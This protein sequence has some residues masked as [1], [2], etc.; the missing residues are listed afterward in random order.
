MKKIA[1]IAALCSFLMPL[2]AQSSLAG[3]DNFLAAKRLPAAL[4]FGNAQGFAWMGVYD[5][6]GFFKDDY[7]LFFA[8]KNLGYVLDRMGSNNKHR[9]IAAFG[10][11]KE[12]GNLYFGSAWDWQNKKFKDGYYSQSVLFRPSD[13]LSLAASFN[14]LFHDARYYEV[15]AAIRP[16]SKLAG[17]GNRITFGIESTYQND[18]WQKPVLSI[19]TELLDGLRLGGNYDLYNEQIGLHFSLS[20][21]NLTMGTYARSDTDNKF[22]YG[23][24]FVHFSDRK[25]KSLFGIEKETFVQFKLKGELLDH[26]KV[27]PLGPLNLVM[28]TGKTID[29]AIKELKQLKND[30]NIAGIIFINEHFASS[31]ALRQ[32]LIEAINEFK[33]AGKKV[34]FYYES[35]GG[36]NYAFAAAVADQIYLNPV[37]MIEFKGL[38]A[39]LPY[40]NSLLDTLGIDIV[41]MRSHDY[42][43]AVN[44]FSESHMTDAERETYEAL[45][46]GIFAEISAMIENGR[47][48]RLA[49]PLSELINEKPF[50]LPQE[51]IEMGLIDGLAFEDELKDLLDSLYDADK[52][53]RKYSAEQYRYDWSDGFPSRI[54]VIHAIGN[55]HSG[56]G[57]TGK[58]IGS[59][60]LASTIKQAREDKTIKGIILRVDSGGGSAIASDVIAREIQLCKTGKNKKPVVVSMSG[61]AA[62]GGYYI[63]MFAD[64]IVC[65]PSTITGSIGVV[66]MLPVMER[67]YQKI[68]INW[69]TVKI[70]QYADF[71]STNRKPTETEIG[72]GEEMIH[73]FYDRFITL[74]AEGRSMNKEDV[75]SVAQ[76]RVWTGKQA[77]ERGLVDTLGGMKTASIEMQ[78]LLNTDKE[79][80]LIVYKKSKAHKSISVPV[81]VQS[82]L[83]REI[84]TFLELADQI[85]NTENDKIMMKVPFIPE[86]K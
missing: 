28:N 65:Q 44:M 57:V 46:D 77:L 71:Q 50:W 61:T 29:E 62:S 27:T 76:G 73:H 74:V 23:Q 86:F 31:I 15:G 30:E 14:D 79:L 84:Q 7:S 32:E 80:D 78:K 9:L 3:T 10:D 21:Q 51:A 1:L 19:D 52:I 12:S 70:G 49:K 16:L 43:T 81:N 35:V 60:S 54:A 53:S 17:L 41:N 8:A 68:H 37:G 85:K 63:S 40:F 20:W 56:K 36:A 58:S 18:E 22:D 26:K 34:V 25:L 55:I 82:R 69:D 13:F 67:L 45:L 24:S 4:A 47:G 6:D 75:H 64:K 5:E 11:G 72:F 59:E 83:P 39:S 2:V 66:G 33:A 38:L 42:K 48:E